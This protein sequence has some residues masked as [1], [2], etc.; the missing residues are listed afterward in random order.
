MSQNSLQYAEESTVASFF[1]DIGSKSNVTCAK[2]QA[3]SM[4]FMRDLNTRRGAKT[5]FS[6]QYIKLE[7]NLA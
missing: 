1:S 2:A 7:N 6:L 5:V 3:F 4:F